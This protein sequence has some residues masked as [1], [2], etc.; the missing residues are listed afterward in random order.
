LE[1]VEVLSEGGYRLVR[2]G[3]QPVDQAQEFPDFVVGVA[4]VERA[5]RQFQTQVVEAI[6][7]PTVALS[8]QM[9]GDEE[10]GA[11]VPMAGQVEL[12]VEVEELADE[13]AEL[14]AA[15]GER[16]TVGFGAPGLVRIAQ[17]GEGHQWHGM[18]LADAVQVVVEPPGQVGV[19][20]H[21]LFKMDEQHLLAAIE[22]ADLDELV[23]AQRAADGIGDEGA[24]LLLERGGVDSPVDERSDRGKGE[25][26]EGPKELV[27]GLLPGAVVVDG[28][29]H[30][31]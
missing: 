31:T 12:F 5:D 15:S 17:D 25:L 19:A 9:G 4:G 13:V 22:L 26:Q 8:G 28:I 23:G 27:E 14:E 7:L 20:L 30:P 6:G 16:D 2:Q 3:H 21:L 29:E 11:V 24:E 18:P 1:L 10:P